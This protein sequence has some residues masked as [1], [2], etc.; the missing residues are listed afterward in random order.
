MH[1]MLGDAAAALA[2]VGDPGVTEFTG[3]P[4]RLREGLD[5]PD[6]SSR[7]GV[8]QLLPPDA[9]KSSC[10]SVFARATEYSLARA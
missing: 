9:A 1:L 2:F 6:E 8:T 7:A 4:S 3:D 5:G 10:S